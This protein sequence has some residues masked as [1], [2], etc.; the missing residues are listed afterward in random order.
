MRKRVPVPENRWMIILMIVG[1]ALLFL[2]V[3]DYVHGAETS[4][5]SA[6]RF[7]ALGNSG[8]A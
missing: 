2:A 6:A 3:V 4:R 7:V 5:A 1:I 8:T